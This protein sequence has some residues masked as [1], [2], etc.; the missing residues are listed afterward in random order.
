MRKRLRFREEME[1]QHKKWTGFR[2]AALAGMVA[3]GLAA[4]GDDSGSTDGKADGGA[5]SG[6]AKSGGAPAAAKGLPG[7]WKVTAA[8]GDS[9]KDNMGTVYKFD[10]SGNLLLGG[11]NK[12]TYT[13][14]TPDLVVKCGT[15]NIKWKVELKPGSKTMTLSNDAKQV[16]ILTRQ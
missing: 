14:K 5:K 3:L 12:C 11:F 4:C 9:A 7:T 10:S 2:F 8:T 15:V 16:L 1:M 13:H 6:G